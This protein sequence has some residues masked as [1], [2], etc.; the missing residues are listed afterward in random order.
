MLL[1]AAV[2]TSQIWLDRAHTSAVAEME[3]DT[4]AAEHLQATKLEGTT[5]LAQMELYIITGLETLVA[6]MPAAEDRMTNHL[7]EA[8]AHFA[9]SGNEEAVASADELLGSAAVIF[10]EWRDIIALRGA[11]DT[12]GATAALTSSLGPMAAAGLKFDQL[13]QAE[14]QEVV[15]LRGRVDSIDRLGFWSLLISGGVG[16]ALGLAVSVAIARSILRPLSALQRAAL[17]VAG[18]DL[19]ARAQPTGP[20]ELAQLGASLNQMTDSLVELNHSLEEKVGQRTQELANANEA[21]KASEERARQVTDTIAEAFWLMEYKSDGTHETLYISPA[22]EQIWGRSCEGLY[23][24]PESWLEAIHPEDRQRV[25]DAFGELPGG[26]YDVEYR[27]VRPD[28][29]VRWVRDHGYSVRTERGE[30]SR[31]AG[32]AA[33]ITERRLAQ[34]ELMRLNRRL[35][36]DR[37]AIRELNRTLERKVRERTEELRL[38]NEELRERNTQLLNARAQAATDALTGLSNHRAFHERIRNEV[39][40]TALEKRRV[41]LIMLDIDAFKRVN[42]SHGHLVGD[43]ILRDAAHTLAEVV[44]HGDIYRYGGDEFAVLLPGAGSQESLEIAEQIRAAVESGLDARGASVTVSL[45]VACFPANAHSAEQ[46]MYGADAAMYWAK[47][48][49]KNRVGDWSELISRRAD[50]THPW[51]L[52][53]HAVKAPDVVAALMAALAAKDPVTSAHTERC[54]LYAA[55]LAAELELNEEDTSIVRLAALLHDIG[56]LAVPDEVLFKP[57]PLNEDEWA[58]MKRHP[59]AALLM[60]AHIHS[61]SDAIPAILHHH[62]HFDGSGYP[63]GLAGS[64]IPIP[65]RILL[66]TD[67][68]DAMTTDRPYRRAMPVDAAIAELKRHSGN[69]FDP[70]IVAAFLKIIEGDGPI[71][72]HLGEAPSRTT[73]ATATAR[74]RGSQSA[75]GRSRL[76]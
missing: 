73:R 39:F 25:L 61:I 70:V 43:Q 56:K 74:P 69:Q 23:G 67:A 18:G 17:A 19:Q 55:R 65:S 64:D 45:G 6:G 10:D 35:E 32:V 54:S 12:Q 33:D 22:Y 72:T 42:D 11:G 31:V 14:R 44:G 5:Q 47:S 3:E 46:L 1:L 62:E 63:D 50:G 28:G 15:D 4:A 66:V 30:A 7:L 41:G 27:V 57:G 52:T 71:H 59:T 2:V 24:H 21:L 51:Y 38:A 13:A 8:R 26:E 68:F 75:T 48:A 36:E 49:G 20:T 60:L 40:R 37:I 9:A 34:E 53:D 16:A 29:S 76:A 58:R